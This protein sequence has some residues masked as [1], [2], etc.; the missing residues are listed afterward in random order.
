[1][2][3]AQ[4]AAGG[5]ESSAVPR[6]PWGDPDLQGV[7]DYRNITPLERPREL[8]DREFY[9]EEEIAELE[10]RAAERLDNPPDENTP[11]NL[12]HA[13]YATDPGRF[14]DE[15]RRTSLIVEPSNGRMPELTAAA[16][17]RQAANRGQG[18]G[19]RGADSYTD[20]TLLERCIT[21]GLPGALL[22]GLYNN[23]IEIVQAPGMVAIIHEMVHETRI[24]PLDGTEYSGLRG[25]MGESRGHWDGDTLVIETKNFNDQVSYRGST[26]DLKLTER[27]T[28][29]GPD[30][31][32]F[33]MTFDD[34]NQ[35]VEPWTVAYSM[36]P[37]QG[38]LYEYACH[39][40]NYGLRN[41]LQNA[42][43]EERA[44]AE[45]AGN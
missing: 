7:W 25:Y 29:I 10:G 24:I 2:A 14:V 16:Q 40:G 38:D 19:G 43:D 45:A 15:A 22:P 36:R 27:Y 44:A 39:E 1:M 31:I 11:A 32:A 33:S 34:P 41:I 28:R 18:F 37:T 4:S 6:T 17:E 3:V 42:R 13:P 20:R 30:Q 26:E 12:V 23:N 9:T 5:S 8:G 35:W 21:R